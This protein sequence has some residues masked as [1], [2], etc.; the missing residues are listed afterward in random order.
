M[1]RFSI[2]MVLIICSLFVIE[3]GRASDT[4]IFIIRVD[5][6]LSRNTSI[7]PRSIL[8]FQQA[9]AER[10]AKVTWAVIPH[11][12][13]ES[14]NQDG[15]LTDELKSTIEEGH[16]VAQHGYNHICPLCGQFH[17]FYCSTYNRSFSYDFQDSLIVA[18]KQILLDSVGIQP[19]SFVPPSHAADST[20]YRV[21]LDEGFQWISTAGSILQNVYP[22]LFNLTVSND[23]TWGLTPALYQSKLRTALQDIRA[24]TQSYGYFCILFHD[25]FIRQGYENGL[26]IQWVGELLDSL[27]HQY[28]NRIQ[29][30]T[31]CEAG[32]YFIKPASSVSMQRSIKTN[33]FVLY[34]NYPN[35]FNTSTKIR[36][37]ILQSNHVKLIIYNFLGQ[38]IAEL[39]NEEK[40][41]GNYEMDFN[42]E[43]LASGIYFCQLQVGNHKSRLNKLVLIK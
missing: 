27:N 16:E 18:G 39:L 4:L 9:V 15:V 25:Y 43:S 30:K 8:P 23:Y 38:Q 12:L 19:L 2:L 40:S 36:F 31:I 35:P 21:L 22:N 13:I 11:R 32:E 37:S 26:V 5:D 33:E 29:Y 6:I 10:G 14:P 41:I 20:T 28:E 7:L 24:Q 1:R 42:G 34:Q 3:A 17:E